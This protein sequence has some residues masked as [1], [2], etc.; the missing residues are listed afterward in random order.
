MPS[1]PLSYGRLRYTN[2][3][4]NKVG[5]GGAVLPCPIL[6]DTSILSTLQPS[7]MQTFNVK[8][9]LRIFVFTVERCPWRRNAVG[10]L[11]PSLAIKNHPWSLGG[12]RPSVEEDRWVGWIRRW[13]TVTRRN[14]LIYQGI[15]DANCV[16][17]IVNLLSTS[18]T[19]VFHLEHNYM[20]TLL[21][22][23]GVVEFNCYLKFIY[24]YWFLYKHYWQTVILPDP[25][26]CGRCHSLNF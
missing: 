3:K 20:H 26:P 1:Q 22:T 23:F 8:V 5:R 24:V 7:S 14:A 12:S 17:T 4:V 18:L 25:P 2:S 16:C 19:P 13:P 6:L 21:D 9:P 15:G 11:R 10:V